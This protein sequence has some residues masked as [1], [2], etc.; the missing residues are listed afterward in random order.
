[1]YINYVGQNCWPSVRLSF[2][3]LLL[4]WVE[5]EENLATCGISE[6]NNPKLVLLDKFNNC[7]NELSFKMMIKLWQTCIIF[8][9]K[10]IGTALPDLTCQVRFEMRTTNSYST[11]QEY[12][13]PIWNME[14]E[15]TMSTSSS[16]LDIYSNEI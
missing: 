14:Y 9:W 3:V 15:V 12:V 1:M 10:I 11:C 7:L 13:A 8:S 5:L 16:I 2:Q 6:K 4:Y